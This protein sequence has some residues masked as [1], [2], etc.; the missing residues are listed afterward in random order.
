MLAWV[1]LL[2]LYMTVSSLADVFVQGLGRPIDLVALSC[3]L[4]FIALQF[5]PNYLDPI[6]LSMHCHFCTFAVLSKLLRLVSYVKSGYR[7]AMR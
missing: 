6:C 4:P 3:P 5:L 7:V 1:N 2:S